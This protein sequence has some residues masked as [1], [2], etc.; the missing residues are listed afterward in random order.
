VHNG[1]GTTPVFGATTPS[2]LR[3]QQLQHIEPSMYTFDISAG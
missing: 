1:C 3:N 2:S